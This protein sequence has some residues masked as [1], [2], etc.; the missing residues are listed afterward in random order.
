MKRTKNIL[1]IILLTVVFYTNNVYAGC[2]LGPNVIRDLAGLYTI[3]KIMVPSIIIALTAWEI[4]NTVLKGDAEGDIKKVAIKFVK[5]IAIAI[6]ILFTPMLVNQ[7]MSILSINDDNSA[8]GSCFKYLMDPS[9]M[10]EDG[11]EQKQNV[12]YNELEMN[13][14][15]SIGGETFI[16]TD[17]QGSYEDKGG[18]TYYAVS[19]KNFNGYG[20]HELTW[21]TSA[22][23]YNFNLG[24]CPFDSSSPNHYLCSST[25]GQNNISSEP[26]M[27]S[28]SR[29]SVFSDST[30]DDVVSFKELAFSYPEVTKAVVNVPH[31][32]NRS[33]C[34]NAISNYSQYLKN[35]TGISVIMPTKEHIKAVSERKV[36]GGVFFLSE[37][38][39][40]FFTQTAVD[41]W[42]TDI[43][44]N[45]GIV[46]NNENPNLLEQAAY[47]FG[48]KIYEAFN[49]MIPPTN[50]L[51]VEVAGVQT[52][53]IFG[54]SK[55]GGDE[56]P[57]WGCRPMI[58][59]NEETYKKLKNQ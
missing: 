42:K 6:L 54:T 2:K 12:K 7:F 9:L 27:G 22:K 50:I 5:R 34:S 4:F 3:L 48:E 29:Q 24:D 19:Q 37:E 55:S 44:S 16:I 39:T 28:G 21:S 41:T 45:L 17:I 43:A 20:N 35:Y 52:N 1:I 33:E 53:E 51:N 31:S 32:V 11:N 18:V 58:K 56:Q 49:D 8:N 40:G 47:K 13:D 46:Y 10:D 57:H 36:K 14:L 38:N 30:N 15:I 23:T 26:S 25:D 59:F